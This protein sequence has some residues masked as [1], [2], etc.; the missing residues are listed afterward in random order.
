M[1]KFV[2]EAIDQVYSIAP[3]PLVAQPNLI[4]NIFFV[5]YGPDVT[6]LV[7]RVVRTVRHSELVSRL[8]QAYQ[9][10]PALVTHRAPRSAFWAARIS[11][12]LYKSVLASKTLGVD[13]HSIFLLSRD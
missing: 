12:C 9:L 3:K 10:L 13:S 5:N 7:V 6:D 11:V 4:N 2:I 8:K 1:L